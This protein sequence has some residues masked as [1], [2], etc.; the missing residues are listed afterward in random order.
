MSL[1]NVTLW[2]I[3]ELQLTYKV[4]A[5]PSVF[6]IIIIIG[7]GFTVVFVVIRNVSRYGKISLHC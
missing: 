1:T 3:T 2:L 7:N 4:T 5:F 6:V